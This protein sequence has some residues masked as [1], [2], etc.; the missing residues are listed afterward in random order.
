MQFIDVTGLS[1]DHIGQIA[2]TLLW[3]GDDRTAD[4]LYAAIEECAAPAPAPFLRLVHS[5]DN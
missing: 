4:E 2:H 1:R 5:T 3:A